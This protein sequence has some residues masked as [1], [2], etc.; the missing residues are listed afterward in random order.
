MADAVFV[1]KLE[2]LPALLSAALQHD[3]ATRRRA[4]DALRVLSKDAAIVP[5]LV[6]ALSQ[7]PEPQIRQL[8]AVFLRKKILALWSRCG[9]PVQEGTRQALLRQLVIESRQASCSCNT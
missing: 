2:D 9:A 3:N 7:A 4:E 6:A 5:P 8:A 1:P